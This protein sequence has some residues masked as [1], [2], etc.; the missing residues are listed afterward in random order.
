MSNEKPTSDVMVLKAFFFPEA[1]ASEGVK[2]LSGLSREDKV[3][4]AEGIRDGSLT[5]A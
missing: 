5:Y 4:L 2:I 1:T 3:A